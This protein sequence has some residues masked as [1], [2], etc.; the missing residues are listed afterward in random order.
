ML[1]TINVQLIEKYKKEKNENKQSTGN[2]N[3]ICK[4]KMNE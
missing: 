2:G 4:Y 3:K 1:R